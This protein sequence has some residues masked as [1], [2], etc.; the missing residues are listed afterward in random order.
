MGFGYLFS[1]IIKRCKRNIGENKVDLKRKTLL[2]SK[3]TLKVFIISLRHTGNMSKGD[4][5]V[6][7]FGI[8]S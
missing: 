6:G 3:Y 5:V 1:I 8:L 2:T 4:N 7:G